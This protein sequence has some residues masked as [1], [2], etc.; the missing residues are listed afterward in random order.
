MWHTNTTILWTF[1]LFPILH[2]LNWSKIINPIEVGLKHWDFPTMSVTYQYQDHL[3][4]ARISYLMSHSLISLRIKQKHL[5]W[6][7]YMGQ[8]GKIIHISLN[9]ESSRHLTI[10][11]VSYSIWHP[12]NWEKK[13]AGAELCLAKHSLS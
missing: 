11:F 2:P 10:A 5:I 7:E 1:H 8:N 12:L 4:P 13:Q 3:T 9:K 6:K